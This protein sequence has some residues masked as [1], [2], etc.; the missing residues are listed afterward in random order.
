MAVVLVLDPKTRLLYRRAIWYW[1]PTILN[2]SILRVRHTF[3]ITPNLVNSLS[4]SYV[5]LF[6]TNHR[7]HMQI[8]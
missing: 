7:G 3:A 2:V 6:A 1:W 5:D 4:A 8:Q